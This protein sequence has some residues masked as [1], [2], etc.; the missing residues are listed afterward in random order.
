MRPLGKSSD[1]AEAR[2]ALRGAPIQRA[3][4]RDKRGRK[5]DERGD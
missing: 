5:R 1:G 2:F 3:I 4:Q